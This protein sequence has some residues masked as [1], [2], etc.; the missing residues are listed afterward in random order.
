ML[1]DCF[2]DIYSTNTG[3]TN[4]GNTNTGTANTGAANTG[5]ANTGTANTGTANTGTANTETEMERK[6]RD[7]SKYQL[8]QRNKRVQ[9]HYLLLFSSF[10]ISFLIS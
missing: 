2:V 8:D 6:Y 4:T 9:P 3:N 10:H 5:T 1:P 7:F